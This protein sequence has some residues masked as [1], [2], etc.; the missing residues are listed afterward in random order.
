[1]DALTR[2][3]IAAT[4]KQVSKRLSNNLSEGGVPCLLHTNAAAGTSLVD[5]QRLSRSI[6]VPGVLLLELS[7]LASLLASAL[8]RNTSLLCCPSILGRCF[9]G[10]FIVLTLLFLEQL[11]KCTIGLEPAVVEGKLVL[12]TS[13]LGGLFVTTLLLTNSALMPWDHA[14]R[15]GLGSTFFAGEDVTAVMNLARLAVRRETSEESL[16]GG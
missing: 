10:F 13:L 7:F 1:M 4:A 16:V 5:L 12:D 2:D 3:M 9:G 6:L 15:A 14:S 8:V 11:L